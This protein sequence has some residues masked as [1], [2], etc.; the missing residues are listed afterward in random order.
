MSA[1]RP[2]TG[3]PPPPNHVYNSA[4]VHDEVQAET[5]L[6]EQRRKLYNDLVQAESNEKTTREKRIADEQICATRQEEERVQSAR[7]DEAQAIHARCAEEHR[8]RAAEAPAMNG[9]S[10]IGPC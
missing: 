6:L 4:A 9:L 10:L 1:A 7:A 2:L 5:N 3:G 8:V